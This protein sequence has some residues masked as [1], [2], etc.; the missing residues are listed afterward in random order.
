MADLIR[1]EEGGKYSAMGIYVGDAL[2]INDLPANDSNI[3]REPLLAIP[4]LYLLVAFKGGSG[5][6]RGEIGI[7]LPSKMPLILA[8]PMEIVCKPEATVVT[9]LPLTPFPVRELGMYCLTVRLDDHKFSYDFEI[10]LRPELLTEYEN[11]KSNRKASSEVAGT[12]T[13]PEK[14][15]RRNKSRPSPSAVR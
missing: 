14:K 1:A 11:R 5:M 12:A 4:Q 3:E 2:V 9:L 6:F 13:E 7:S 10:R 8:A 15:T